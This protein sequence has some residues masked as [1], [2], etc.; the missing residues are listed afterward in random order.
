MS[1]QTMSN[2]IAIN[3]EEII[4]NNPKNLNES[5]SS[6]KIKNLLK[7]LLKKSLD[8]PLLKL[9]SKMKNCFSDIK[10]ISKN[11]KEDLKILNK[12][13]KNVDESLKQKEKSSKIKNKSNKKEPILKT[14]KHRQRNPQLHI[15]TN[16]FSSNNMPFTKKSQN[17]DR[18]NDNNIKYNTQNN[19]YNLYKEKKPLS[20]CSKSINK[21]LSFNNNTNPDENINIGTEL[22]N[23]N[24]ILGYKNKL[25]LFISGSNSITNKQLT[26]S[27]TGSNSYINYT[28]A[29]LTVKNKNMEN[30]SFNRNTNFIKVENLT[31]EKAGFNSS[32]KY[33]GL[34]SDLFNIEEKIEKTHYNRKN[35]FKEKENP[36]HFIKIKD[37][38][39]K[40]ISEQ[41]DPKLSVANIIKLVDDVN[42]NINRILTGSQTSI[43]RKNKSNNSVFNNFS[44]ERIERNNKLNNIKEEIK[45]NI[46]HK[47]GNCYSIDD[48]KKLLYNNKSKEMQKNFENLISLQDKPK[49][50]ELNIKKVEN[51]NNVTKNKKYIK[52]RI[53]YHLKSTNTET[54][55][56]INKNEI[57]EKNQN[58]Q[59]TA[60]PKT[61]IKINYLEILNQNKKK[62]LNLIINYL[63]MEDKLKFFSLNKALLIE[64]F[65]Y[66]NNRKKSIELILNLKKIESISFKKNGFFKKIKE[67]KKELQISNEA[68]KRLKHL[69]NEQ[70][71]SFFKSNN[72]SI[73]KVIIMI[74][75]ILFIFIGKNNLVEIK[76]DKIFWKKCC[77]YLLSNSNLGNLIL[78]KIQSFKYENKNIILIEEIIMG[79]KDNFV[80]GNYCKLNKMTSFIVPVLTEIIEYCGIIMNYKKT[81]VAKSLNNIKNIQMLIDKL[82]G[83]LKKE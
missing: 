51:N 40:N 1:N 14:A 45:H 70:N 13:S 32:S 71:L 44:T 54:I 66:L 2:V 30:L 27:I 31:Q 79:N 7:N 16:T 75:K 26:S 55:T 80:N 8:N 19:F 23:D 39:K 12:I 41:K 46:S 64:R 20:K 72:T 63:N 53:V 74:F 76:S 37:N 59:N 69:N 25:K 4:E 52:P 33:L 34:G 82:N 35:K 56:K 43:G 42:Q 5:L 22:E 77:N 28:T 58:D 65:T 9:E 57:I 49:F 17:K 11:F 36:L 3:K 68:I 29:N 6:I 73:S 67:D 21:T 83:I 24:K 10:I 18:I 61:I 78:S 47:N 62:N 48:A 81:S 15:L 60:I 38:K 50:S